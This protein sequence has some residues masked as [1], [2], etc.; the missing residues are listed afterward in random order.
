MAPTVKENWR[1]A[2]KMCSTEV[3]TCDTP[4][5]IDIGMH[6]TPLMF[7][8]RPVPNQVT[9]T[10]NIRILVK[11]R[12]L[13]LQP[14]TEL[15]PEQW[16]GVTFD[17]K[18]SIHN[19]FGFGLFED[20]HLHVNGVL[21][22]TAQR[23]YP[24]TSYIKNLLF[25]NNTEKRMLQSALFYEDQ[26]GYIDKVLHDSILNQ[27][28]AIRTGMTLDK[29]TANFIAPLYL[30][31]LQAGVY[32]PD[33]IGMTLHL[34]PT[35]P[36][37]CVICDVEPV[38]QLK[39]EIIDAHL[40]VPRCQL[41]IPVL[42]SFTTQY[43]S[44]K[45][46]SYVN[47]KE[48]MSF[49]RSLNINQLPKK[50]AI[51]VLDEDQ[52]HGVNKPSALNFKHHDVKSIRVRCNGQTYPT[53]VGMTMDFDKADYREPYTALFTQLKAISPH[54]FINHFDNG[55][56]IFGVD[57]P[58]G[59]RP[60]KIDNGGMYGTCDVDIDFATKPTENLVILVFCFYDSQVSFNATNG[61]T[62]NSAEVKL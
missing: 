51:V 52:D 1:D 8:V 13:K 14:A 6:R 17:D 15:Q 43:E 18:V 36:T 41:S 53:A 47:P 20:V 29:K 50:L 30:D 54:F 9:D 2:V 49:S 48:V 60:A 34:Y 19:N 46:L 26:P 59:H 45:V 28:E 7:N 35:Q 4:L 38:P 58:P 24:R 44:V 5:P 3:V 55:Y 62:H 40:H 12:V 37:N 32:F 11:F 21:V 33:H 10:K 39:V 27:G 22:E 23:E 57:L 16:V 61:I 25:K 42:K 31:L 56:A